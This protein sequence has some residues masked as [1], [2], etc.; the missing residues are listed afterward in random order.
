MKLHKKILRHMLASTMSFRVWYPAHE[1][2]TESAL[3][4]ATRRKMIDENKT[5]CMV[6]G[7]RDK[8]ELHHW[9]VEWAYANAVD[10]RKMRKL[11]PQ[12]DWSQFKEAA[13]FVDSEYNC[14]VL[15]VK[16]H[17]LHAYG[18]HNL[19][20]PIWREQMHMP[21]DWTFASIKK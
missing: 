6:C 14:R 16:H 15:C 1:Q 11:H 8:L 5:P 17:R 9:L 20:Y 21:D 18:I 3:F 13:D 4:R 2:R 7:T 10:W 12:F 19:P